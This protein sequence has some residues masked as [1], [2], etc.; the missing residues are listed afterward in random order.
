[1]EINRIRPNGGV[2]QSP[3]TESGNAKFKAQTHPAQQSENAAA[4]SPLA[5]VTRSDLADATKRE[6]AVKQSFERL[7]DDAATKLGVAIT[8]K[9]KQDLAGFL[10]NDPLLRGKLLNHLSQIAK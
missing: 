10:Q 9:Q 4:A 3:G 7:L 1:M 5:G 6:D 8:D 2:E